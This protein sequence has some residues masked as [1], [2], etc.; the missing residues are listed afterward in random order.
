VL[1]KL[2]AWDAHNVTEDADLGIRL[3]RRGYRTVFIPSVTKEEANGHFWP[4]VRQRSRWLKGYAITYLVHMRRPLQLLSELGSWKFLGFQVL[5]LGTLVN[6][7]FAPF[8][9]L[10][11][12]LPI[13]GSNVYARMFSEGVIQAGM[14][15]C[16]F[17]F[18][19]NLSIA[20]LGL[21]KAGKLRMLP[22]YF[23][24][25]AYFPLASLA[26]YKGLYELARRPFF[27]DKTEHGVLLPQ[28]D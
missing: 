10:F 26:V 11:W 17:S 24:M 13:L 4:W 7:V 2:G 1:D 14:V 5:F 9:W 22:W 3:A 25:V 18:L 12:L 23:T 8:V 20:C 27:W 21:H 19:A 16:L 28:K 6:F 15:I